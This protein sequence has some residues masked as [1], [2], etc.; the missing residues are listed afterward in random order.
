MWQDLA[1][2]NSAFHKHDY[3][4]NAGFERDHLAHEVRIEPATRLSRLL[5]STRCPVNSMHH[6][7]IK[8]LGRDLVASATA[9]DGLIEAIEGTA[10]AFLV[11]VQWHPEVFEMADPHTRHLFGGFIRAAVEW[12]TA[13]NAP[14]VGVGD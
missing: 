4:P 10:D 6:Q 1:S 13:N 14:R 2:Q 3:F 12:S 7:G 8:A 11:G 9:D 5:E